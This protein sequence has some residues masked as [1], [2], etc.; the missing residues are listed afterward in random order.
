MMDI[1][2]IGAGIGGLTLANIL[3]ETGHKVNIFERD[4]SANSRPQGYGIGL[5]RDTGQR[6]LNELNLLQQAKES[7]QPL[8]RFPFLL[9]DGDEVFTLEM[10][11]AYALLSISRDDLRRMLIERVG[12]NNIA[13]GKTFVGYEVE[14]EKIKAK[15]NDGSIVT[16]D[17]LIGFDGLH[18]KVHKQLD[19]KSLN[20]LGLVSIGGMLT[21]SELSNHRLLQGGAFISIGDCASMYV[22]TYTKTGKVL[23]AYSSHQQD[24]WG[25]NFDREKLKAEVYSRIRTWHEPIPTLVKK[26]AV[27]SIGQPI[28][29]YDRE[30]VRSTVK[31]RV[32]LLGDAA[33]PMSPYQGQGA[34]FAMLDALELGTLLVGS[35]EVDW[36]AM[37]SFKESV[38]KRAS[39]AVLTSRRAAKDFHAEDASKRISAWKQGAPV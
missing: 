10:P 17:L 11:P 36:S 7:G 22:Q 37:A 26:T 35:T 23:W 34:N 39:S 18:S 16:G 24:V 29:I 1:T 13:W 5:N 2:I 30:P 14:N 3:Q 9:S 8:F 12:E 33:H 15:F 27:E 25:R 19:K 6:V 38:W 21:G 31:S 4:K 32:I 20:Y 28:P